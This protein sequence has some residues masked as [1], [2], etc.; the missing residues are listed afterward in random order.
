MVGRHTACLR[1]NILPT[2]ADKLQ[3]I[4][5]KPTPALSVAVSPTS[6]SSPG[7]FRWVIVATLCAVALVLYVDRIN[8][9]I[10]APLIAH[11]LG[12]SPQALGRV[13]SAFLFVYALGLAPGGWLADRFGAYRVLASA[14]AFWVILSLLM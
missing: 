13:L 3:M 4:V 10:A 7:H 1:A 5:A 11:E 6:K 8:I 12:L 9:A 14:G 2:V